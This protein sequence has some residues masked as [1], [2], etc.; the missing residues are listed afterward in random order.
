MPH[1]HRTA[2]GVITESPLAL[3][4][5]ITDQ[6]VVGN[7]MIFTSVFSGGVEKPTAYGAVGYDGPAGSARQAEDWARRG[8]KGIKAKIEY[9]SVKEDVG[10]IRAI[11]KSVGGD[12]AIVDDNPGSGIEWDEAAIN[13]CAV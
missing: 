8:S 2:G 11:R 6:G 1:P 10:V 13:R 4:D 7:S 9:P 12:M 3:T 5:A